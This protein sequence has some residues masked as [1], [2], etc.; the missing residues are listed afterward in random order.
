[1]PFLEDDFVIA[2]KAFTSRLLIGSARFPDPITRKK[3]VE[4]S[5]AE[6]VTVA[7]RRKGV[8]LHHDMEG[9]FLLP[10]TAG[11][12]T[13]K[14]AILYAHLAKEALNTN[15]IK[16][17]VIGDDRTLY[18]DCIELLKAAK[19]LVNEGFVVLPYCS[20]DPVTARKLMDMGC[21]AIM[22][23]GSPIGT[24]RG[25]LNPYNLEVIR[26]EISIPLIVD[27]GLGC[28]SDAAIAMDLGADAILVNTAIAE[29]IDPVAMAK[30]FR[31]CV[32]GGRLGYKAGKIAKKDPASSSP[33]E[34]K[35]T[36]TA[37]F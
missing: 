29:A 10:N 23:L 19:E 4:A 33:L 31:L 32:E 16:L 30:G 11:C 1:M 6:I 13:A 36:C 24:G 2:G 28:P 3:A 26:R 37:P 14:E 15:W 17:E 35:I 22:P 18:P 25:I 12:Y 7:I 27:A 5:G 21:S 20:D 9:Y 34:G 8:H